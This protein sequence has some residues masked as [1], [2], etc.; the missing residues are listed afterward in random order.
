VDTSAFPRLTVVLGTRPEIVKLSPLLAL[1]PPDSFTLVHTGQHYSF[2]MDELFFRELA[3]PAPMHA[4]GIGSG[5]HGAQTGAMLA[6]IERVVLDDRPDAVIVQ[7]DTNSALAGALAAA[8]QHVP[9]IHLEAGCR[10]GNR[11]M[12]EELNRILVGRCA[13]LH[14]APHQEAVDNL[15]HEGIA[16]DQVQL[17]GSTSIDAC[18]LQAGRAADR[19]SALLRE[20]EVTGEY[21]VA[22]LHRAENTTPEVLPGIMDALAE[23]SRRLPVVLPLHPRTRAAGA[24]PRADAPNLRVIEPVGYLGALA[25]FGGA[26]LVLS[27]SGGIQEEAPALGTPVVVMRGDTEWG[28]LLGPSGNVLAGNQREGILSAA[29][30]VLARGRRVELPQLEARAGA[31]ERAAAAIAA[32]Y[33]SG[34]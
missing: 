16:G 13:D 19:R 28:D 20:L 18:R 29:A 26:R 1:L 4:L 14:L 5:Q 17:I 24:G 11:A 21:A 8:K 34:A 25:L 7:G 32:R 9:V 31:A 10:S 2:A 27:D 23:L 30:E 33:G 12:P 6:G 3:L 15:A 22:T